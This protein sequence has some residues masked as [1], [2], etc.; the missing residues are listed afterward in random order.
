MTDRS[1]HGRVD[2]RYPHI[3]IVIPTYN[4]PHDMQRELESLARVEY[5]CW[6]V[7]VVDQSDDNQTCEIVEKFMPSMPHLRYKHLRAKGTSRARNVG[8]TETEGEI[9]G[10]LDHDC[11]V[12]PDWLMQVAAV[13]KRY[14][15]AAN[16]FGDVKPPRGLPQWSELGWTPCIETPEE[17][18]ASLR[19]SVVNRLT[20]PRLTSM[21]ACMFVRRS[22]SQQIGYF[23]VHFG[24]GARFP[25][26]EDG[27]YTYRTLMAG[28]SVVRTP[29]ICVEH[30]G[31]RD[32]PNGAASRH[33]H[34]YRYATGAWHMK[35]LRLGDPFALAWVVKEAILYLSFIRPLN[36]ITRRGANNLSHILLYALGML[37]SFKL[38]VDRRNKLY[39]A[40][41]MI[42]H[43]D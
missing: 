29:A 42:W 39:A 33:M 7:L 18:E 26:C 32:Y 38:R 41:S 23:D 5:P 36:L 11:T 9:I 30:H 8:F 20:L 10:F 14:P 4:A 37:H 3:S 2:H 35:A 43:A 12:E 13:V 24:P 27:D 21:G 1:Q 16:I 31:I 6:D 17:F 40:R 19:D 15:Q 34:T 28:F 22:A 25:S